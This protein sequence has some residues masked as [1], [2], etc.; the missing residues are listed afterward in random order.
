MAD[1]WG[2]WLA[3]GQR[4]ANPPAIFHVNWFRK[5]DAGNF[6]WPGYG[7]NV[8]VLR[9][10]LERTRGAG[11]GHETPI[12][13]VPNADAL[14]LDGLDLAPATLEELLRVT[15]ADW[16]QDWNHFGRFLEQFGDRLPAGIRAQHTALGRRLGVAKG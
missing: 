10:M 7:E 6:L 15:P 5:D 14:D 4:I 2:H 9:W 16:A 11:G 8:R 3:M 1:Y 13:H 12:G